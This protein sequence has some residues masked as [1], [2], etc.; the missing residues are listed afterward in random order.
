MN[1]AC[2]RTDL[3]KLA[4]GLDTEIG[5][6][7]INL[8]GG[9]KQRLAIA[10]AVLANPGLVLLDDAISALDEKT[11]N[12]LCERLVFVVWRHHDHF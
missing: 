5:E 11:G 8:S 2:F 12:R 4:N 1:F 10:R 9:Q 7:G 6:N 3:E